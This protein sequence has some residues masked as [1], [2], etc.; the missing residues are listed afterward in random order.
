MDNYEWEKG[1]LPKFGLI[2]I[3]YKNLERKIRESAIFYA[4]ICQE[5]SLTI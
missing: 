3:D 5:N 4:K 2:E 1:F